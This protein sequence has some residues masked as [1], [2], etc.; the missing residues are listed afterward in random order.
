M[1]PRADEKQKKVVAEKIKLFGSAGK[2]DSYFE[3]SERLKPLFTYD[4]DTVD[5]IIY[6]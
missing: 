2:A 3:D 4:A 6:D 5:E 1:T